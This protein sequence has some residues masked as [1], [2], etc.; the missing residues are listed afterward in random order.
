MTTERLGNPTLIPQITGAG[1]DGEGVDNNS[2]DDD[3]D[4]EGICV[5]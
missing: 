1:G 3:D 5:A 2:G 4:E